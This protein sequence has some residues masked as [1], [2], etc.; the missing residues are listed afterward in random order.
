MGVGKSASRN[1]RV[2]LILAGIEELNFVLSAMSRTIPPHIEFDDLVGEAILKVVESV[3]RYD[4]NHESGASFSTFVSPRIKGCIIT[5]LR[6]YGGAGFSFVDV[7]V[8]ANNG[9]SRIFS[10]RGEESDDIF[11]RACTSTLSTES[12]GIDEHIILELYFSRNQSVR[13][14]AKGASIAASTATRKINAAL[15][16][17]RV[18]NFVL[19]RKPVTSGNSMSAKRS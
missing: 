12:L 9:F 4:P 2:S 19:M 3:D 17:L 14:I 10:D 1:D 13:D 5:Y 8:A 15:D 11:R 16:K 6:K 7:D 18:E